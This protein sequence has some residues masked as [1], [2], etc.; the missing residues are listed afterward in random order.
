MKRPYLFILICALSSGLCTSSVS[1]DPAGPNPELRTYTENMTEQV[2]IPGLYVQCVDETS[3]PESI[4]GQYCDISSSPVPEGMTPPSVTSCSSF[5]GSTAPAATDTPCEYNTTII[6]NVLQQADIP[7]VQASL[8]CSAIQGSDGWCSGNVIMT[9]T[10]TE[11]MPD[12]SLNGAEISISGEG[13][14]IYGTQPYVFE[15][16]KEGGHNIAYRVYSTVGDTSVTEYAGIRID[17]TAPE[18]ACEILS[19]PVYGS[20][21]TGPVE[22][23]SLSSDD[24]SGIYESIFEAEGRTSEGSIILT[25]TGKDIT[26]DLTAKDHAFNTARITCAEVSIDNTI[27]VL[28]SFTIPDM[29]PYGTGDI[30]FSVSGHDEGAGVRSVSVIIDSEEYAFSGDRVSTSVSFDNAGMHTL[31]Y[32]ITDNVGL[33][34]E[35]PV[36][37]FS[38][39]TDSPDPVIGIRKN[40]EDS[41]NPVPGGGYLRLFV[42]DGSMADMLIRPNV[43]DANGDITDD[44][45]WIASARA[46]VY[47]GGYDHRAIELSAE[48]NYAFR[49]DGTFPKD[50]YREVIEGEIIAAEGSVDAPAGWYWLTIETTDKNGAISCWNSR[51]LAGDI[52]PVRQQDNDPEYTVFEIAGKVNAADTVSVTVGGSR[53]MLADF[54]R[55]GPDISEGISVTGRGRAYKK[56]NVLVVESLKAVEETYFPFSGLIDDLGSSYVIIDGQSMFLANETEK[57]CEDIRSGDYVSGLFREENGEKIVTEFGPL[58]CERNGIARTAAGIVGN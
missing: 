47:G 11:P 55:I 14:I 28:D 32:R 25:G 19:S 33:T 26:V 7:S 23:R 6:T 41:E 1:A 29:D 42:P 24:L 56:E 58:S 31:S 49:W 54:S 39:E 22:F 51:I 18:A 12:Y 36:F 15:I 5:A 2:S 52:Q 8:S 17:R 35:S 30:M 45:S 34:A 37:S 10:G 48:N 27:P 38:V 4:L 13:Q 57:Y 40:N 21:H 3:S 16:S 53:Y 50:E 43:I 9:V 44:Y 20:W 46:F